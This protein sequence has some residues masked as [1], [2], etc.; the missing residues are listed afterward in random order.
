MKRALRHKK[1]S[2]QISGQPALHS[3]NFFG[4]PP[5][6]IGQHFGKLNLNRQLEEVTALFVM[7]S[8]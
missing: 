1:C 3:L 5:L 4:Q 2:D 6:E 8:H 7:K